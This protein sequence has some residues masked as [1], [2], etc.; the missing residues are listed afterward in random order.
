M[1]C[2]APWPKPP[3]ARSPLGWRVWERVLCDHSSFSAQCHLP[4]SDSNNQPISIYIAAHYKCAIY[5]DQDAQQ[6]SFARH[7]KETNNDSGGRQWNVECCLLH[8][9]VER[10]KR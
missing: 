10:L 3:S 7:N 8:K 5:E 2:S 4:S 1:V 9:V 6:P